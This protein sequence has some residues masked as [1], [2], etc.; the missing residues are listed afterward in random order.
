MIFCGWQFLSNCLVEQLELSH[1]LQPQTTMNKTKVEGL[2][3]TAKLSFENINVNV[4]K[5][6]V[7]AQ[8]IINIIEAYEEMLFSLRFCKEYDLRLVT[9]RRSIT[10]TTNAL[11]TLLKEIS[12]SIDLTIDDRKLR[13]AFDGILS[14]PKSGEVRDKVIAAFVDISL[15]TSGIIKVLAVRIQQATYKVSKETEKVLDEL[16][17][18]LPEID[19]IA[20]RTRSKWFRF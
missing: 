12:R 20:S 5:I 7:E 8:D 2:I 6:D 11:T 16:L 13:A 4:D 9:D 3:N 14:M 15:N 18:L 10:D 17:R 19:A 1:S